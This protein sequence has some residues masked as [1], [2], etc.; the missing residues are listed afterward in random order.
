MEIMY[1]QQQKEKI[2]KEI[3]ETACECRRRAEDPSLSGAERLSA[4][5]NSKNLF[6]WLNQI[7][8][9]DA[10]EENRMYEGAEICLKLVRRGD[11]PT[12]SVE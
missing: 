6:G 4:H 9:A 7:D 5:M 10:E 1:N 11:Q 12:T 8:S 3:F 2:Y